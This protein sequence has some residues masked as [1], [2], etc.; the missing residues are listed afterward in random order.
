MRS[1]YGVLIRQTIETS[2]SARSFNVGAVSPSN[3]NGA[4]LFPDGVGQN[5]ERAKSFDIPL[6][7]FFEMGGGQ[8]WVTTSSVKVFHSNPDLY[9]RLTRCPMMKI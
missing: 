9:F 3:P 2:S 1:L 6:P 5:H 7:N 8:I 4:P